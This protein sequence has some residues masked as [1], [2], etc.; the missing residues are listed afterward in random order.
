[1]LSKLL[2]LENTIL[3]A[4]A[5]GADLSTTFACLSEKIEMVLPMSRCS[6]LLV[7]PNGSV[8][9]TRMSHLAEDY[10]EAHCREVIAPILRSWVATGRRGSSIVPGDIPRLP[11]SC[12]ADAGA[13]HEL[14]SYWLAP[15]C[16]ASGG[17]LGAVALLRLD[18][19]GPTDTEQRVLEACARLCA[20]A[21][22]RH[23]RA[24]ERERRANVDALTLL[25]N[26]FAF[27]Q[28]LSLL[29]CD[30]PGTWGLLIVDLDNLKVVN[31]TFGHHAGDCLLQAVA[32]RTSAASSPEKVFRIGGDEF[33]I[34]VQSSDSLRDLDAFAGEILSALSDGVPCRGHMLVPEATIGGAVLSPGDQAA[35]TVRRN[36]D[37]A[38]YHA[39]ETGR[40]G[41]VRY[42]PGL[43]T[44]I[45]HRLSAIRDLS[46][47]LEENRIEPHYQPIVRLG[48]DQ[49][50]ALEAL[51]RLRTTAGRIV[52]ASQFREAL[53]DGQ[54]ASALTERMLSLIAEDI[55]TW[56]DLEIPIDHVSINIAAADLYGGRLEEQLL[57]S[58][59]RRGVALGKLVLEISETIAPVRHHRLVPKRI[60][61]LRQ[62]GL[63]IALDDFGGG[64]AS[65]TQLLTEPID[66]LKLD[67][68][69]IERFCAEPETGAVLEALLLV[70]GRLGIAVVAQ[71]IETEEQASALSR[72]GFEHGQ[73]YLFSQP[74]DRGAATSLLRNRAD[75]V[76]GTLASAG[77]RRVSR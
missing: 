25:D 63:R 23:E 32:A 34:I 75:A 18:R 12:G 69:L 58:F 35:E 48:T 16:A 36:A 46:A 21:L 6:V 70:A 1:M 61:A 28:M 49:I 40:G 17:L 77:A 67:R 33:A 42:W 14:Q 72:L 54:L 10:R 71:G 3:E 24:V 59:E 68:G 76:A 30:A 73:G 52:A 27:N 53:S 38:L 74:L 26:R 62:F 20:I 11:E 43:E 8:D 29:P 66:G 65:L 45:T 37:F 55:R 41:F 56:Q 47:A 13:L 22:E 19:R 7:D 51:A 64:S 50:V 44:R 60:A 57:D 39:K 5:T 2:V 4:I 15:I 31:D 9:G